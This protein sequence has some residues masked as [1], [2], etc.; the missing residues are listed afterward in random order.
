VTDQIA[1]LLAAAAQTSAA[2][3]DMI[4]AA[5]DGA[6]LPHGNVGAGDTLTILADGMRLLIEAMMAE[7]A[8]GHEGDARDDTDQLHGALVLFLEDRA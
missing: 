6:I 7:D 4:E 3:S 5:R 1:K 2:T 8:Y